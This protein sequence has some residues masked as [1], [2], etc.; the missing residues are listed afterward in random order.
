MRRRSG[1][2][3][4]QEIIVKRRK[5]SGHHE[6][7]GGAWKVAFADFTMAMMA[8]FMVLWVITPQNSS[9]ASHADYQTNPILDGG[10]GVFDG[11]SR[12]PVELEG[13]PV[14]TQEQPK[15]I[16][17]AE[18]AMDEDATEQK[19]YAKPEQLQE[20]AQLMET[21]AI[22][23]DAS[24][25]I[26][27]QVVPQGLRILIKDD[28][29]RFMFDRG[30]ARMNPYFKTLLQQLATILGGVAN[31]VIISGHT[32][33]VPYKAANGYNNWNLSGDRA[34]SARNVMV[35]AGLPKQSVLQVAAQADVMPLRPDAPEDGVNRRI[36]VLLLTDKAESLY[37]DLFGNQQALV[38]YSQ[39][40]A[41]WVEPQAGANESQQKAVQVKAA[42][43]Q[44]GELHQDLVGQ[45]Q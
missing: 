2:K 7:H 35:D 6:A 22:K 5:K 4:H 3:E 1:D 25:N 13:T 12:T 26:E 34:L 32:D 27:V 16:Q 39:K 14:P 36:E 29:Q 23:L 28:E 8:L 30:N 20:L 31:K 40:G 10:A 45:L 19:R 17:A 24:A 21:L 9:D 43:I 15:V 11:K 18:E 37:R 41:N 44:P 33:S 42:Q 38:K